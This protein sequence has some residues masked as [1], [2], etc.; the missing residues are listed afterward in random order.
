MS[1]WRHVVRGAR[2]LAGRSRADE[3]LDE[4]IRN[5]MQEAEAARVAEGHSRDE[6]RRLVRLE[7]GHAIRV[8]EEVRSA[9]WEHS[10]GTVVADIRY[11]ARRLA[12]GRSFTAVAIVTLSVG[13]GATTAIFGAVRAVLLEPLPYPHADRV[14]M[15]SDITSQGEP[16]PVTFGTYREIAAR[17]RAF[18]ALAP[19]RFWQPTLAGRFEPERL[20]GELVGAGFFHAL[21][22]PP[23]MGRDFVAAEDRP[24]GARVAII[25]HDLWRRRFGADPAILG[26]TTTL[27]GTQYEVIG[28]MPAT[29][30]NAV[31][32]SAE[33]WAP[34]QY[35]TI[36]GPQSREWGHHLRLVGRLQAGTT[37]E[38]AREELNQI[39]RKPV[40]D[41]P[42]VAWAALPN[43]LITTS[44]QTDMT[45]A[46][47]PMLID[48]F[49]G[50]ILLLVIACVN[51]TNLLL[52]RGAQRRG[53]FAVRAALGAG[54]R[55]L[56]QQ[57][58]TESVLLSVISGAVAVAVAAIVCSTLVA[59]APPGL[60]RVDSIRVDTRVFGF[61]LLLATL[62]GTLV[63]IV[64][65]VTATGQDLRAN[66]QE[67]SR[68]AGTRHHRLRRFLVAAEVAVALV[69]LA[70]AGL[71]FRSV[72]HVYAAPV[73]FT[74]SGLLTMQVQKLG[75]PG[76]S[77]ATRLRFYTRALEAVRAVPG[78]SSAAY[79]SLLPLGIFID[80]Y[81]IHFEADPGAD[82]DGAAL[83]YAVSPD[84]FR[85]LELPL[86]TGR[87]LDEH[88][89]ATAPR[90]ALLN[91]AFAR[92]KFGDRGAI[93]QRFRLGPTEGD[94]YTVVGV[95]GDTHQSALDVAPPDAVY[96]TAEQWHWVDP[97]MTIIIRGSGDVTAL[98]PLVRRAIWSVDKDVP[99][100]REATM[101]DLRKRAIADRSF[102]LTL[103][104]AFGLA[105][106]VLV[107]TGIYGVLSGIVTERTQEIGIRAALGAT[108]GGV[109]GL[110]V[111]DGV[112]LAIAGVVIGLTIAAAT[113]RAL[114]ALLF[115]VSPLDPPTYA[116][117]VVL[118]LA[119]SVV[120]CVAPAYRAASIDPSVALRVE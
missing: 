29:F 51:V 36:Y 91:E 120:A 81:G 13:I 78:V 12:R 44:L 99:V 19:I 1:L 92:R 16:L 98:A 18:E 113:T 71:L 60:P 34:L 107:T 85:V 9:G 27:D 41:F 50:V 59:L 58:L 47:R 6:A 86:R 23:A 72:D 46:I 30:R 42:R 70:S 4:E 102:A 94:W 40:A 69:L 93:G 90:A 103:F 116:A 39:A 32:P 95:V 106:L 56:F 119:A 100:V 38:A 101:G 11:A 3:D 83:R 61:A 115:G 84:Y 88:D 82:A 79:T 111:R 54:R 26:R 77:N 43:G 57:L 80:V 68:R 62:V 65:A 96:I 74:A 105:A 48:V 15:I 45:R 53:E 24:D 7:S 114:G 28:V 97:A 22:V 37:L 21:G 10:V 55:R 31:A 8:R 110:V 49:G 5:Y 25:S 33:I 35:N 118:L 52:A 67:T 117:V 89:T 73:G 14:V 64:P 17:A 108:R 87:L 109:I 63:G 76:D 112:A 104:E 2:V 75:G 66:A 20:T